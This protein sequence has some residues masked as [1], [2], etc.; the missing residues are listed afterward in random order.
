M[1]PRLKSIKVKSEDSNSHI[2]SDSPHKSPNHVLVNEY[3]PGQGIFPHEDGGAYYSVVA[4][5]SLGSSIV[6]DVYDKSSDVNGMRQDMQRWRIIQEP[7]SL[8]ITAEDVYKKHL[9]GISETNVDRNLNSESISNWEMLGCKE[10]YKVGIK[11]RGTRVSLTFRDV[12]EVKIIGKGLGLGFLG[13]R[14]RS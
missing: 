12:L 8:L 9:H 7:R 4:T 1:I 3:I 10:D 2:F 13:S 14:P 11:E 5:V 6:F